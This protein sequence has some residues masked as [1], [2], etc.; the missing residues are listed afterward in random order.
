MRRRYTRGRHGNLEDDSRGGG[1]SGLDSQRSPPVSPEIRRTLD[2]DIQFH[3]AIEQQLFQ[4]WLA[5]PAVEVI[6]DRPEHSIMFLGEMAA[7][8]PPLA[9]CDKNSPYLALHEQR[10]RGL[11]YRG[12][13]GKPKMQAIRLGIFLGNKQLKTTVFY[14][15]DYQ[16]DNIVPLSGEDP[17]KY[18]FQAPKMKYMHPEWIRFRDLKVIVLVYIRDD[19]VSF[20]R[21]VDWYRMVRTNLEPS[22]PRPCVLLVQTYVRKIDLCRT[23]CKTRTLRTIEQYHKYPERLEE[24]V[25]AF[26]D[27]V[28]A[29]FQEID[30]ADKMAPKELW[31]RVAT[32]L[33][34]KKVDPDFQPDATIVDAKLARAFRPDWGMHRG[35]ARCG[36]CRGQY[37]AAR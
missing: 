11:R 36:C 14:L 5:T 21:A 8:V 10:N 23:Q 28:S 15:R 20:S 24:N 9:T 35:L 22:H 7:G 4:R 1:S 13:F 34:C 31:D 3:S 37:P 17:S 32:L 16:T 25:K 26:V 19:S 2:I 29:D 12:Y 30:L 6:S 27:E 18:R 33:A